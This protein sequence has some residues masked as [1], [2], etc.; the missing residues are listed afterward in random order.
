MKVTRRNALKSAAILGTASLAGCPT[1]NLPPGSD[2][3]PD[4]GPS[5]S[6]VPPTD[7][8][9]VDAWAYDGGPPPTGTFQHGVASGD[10]MPDAVIL[11]TRVSEQT[12]AVDVDWEIATDTAFAAVVTSGTFNTDAARDFTVKV[13]ATGL[14]P[15][16][17]YYYR[18]TLGGITSPI[19]RTKTAPTGA[20]SRLRFAFCSCSNYQFGF[21]H[22]YRRI[23][24]RADLDAVIHLGDYIYEF[25][26][27]YYGSARASDPPTEILSL[28][29]YRRRYAHYREDHDLQEAHRQHP[30]ITTWDDHEFANDA[31]E[32]G[33]QNHMP[34]T[35]G[36]WNTRKE[37]AKQ[38]YREWMPYREQPSG[39]IRRTL[40]YGDLV[41]LII[42][43][44]R[45]E[46]RQEQNSGDDATRELLGSAQETFLFDRLMNSPAQ[47]KLVCQQVMFALSPSGSN[48]DQWEGYPG[49]RTRVIEF[50][51]DN[52]IDNAVILTGDIHCSWANDIPEDPATYDAATGAG[53]VAVEM[54][55]PAI[56]SPG[57]GPIPAAGT[58]TAIEEHAHYV[59]FF[60]PTERGYVVLDV[61]TAR[62][63]GAWY[64]VQNIADPEAP[65]GVERF[66]A[67]LSIADGTT[68]L[69]TDAAAAP[70][71]ADPPTLAP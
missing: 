13:D 7:A 15:A 24:E 43:D 21:F 69:V 2:G 31:Y 35:E 42:L 38:V 23:S 10:P 25:Q 17:T 32:D 53:S 27:G 59:R 34:A 41:E 46:A 12:A 39:G 18:F 8:G 52:A 65:G 62:T 48:P 71:V 70:P 50:L 47:W 64:F 14:S 5:D 54:V 16:T 28:D 9:P 66:A 58:R 19:G 63:Q 20:T 40:T 44:T 51:R 67:A 36:D 33:A 26:N 56:T 68:N 4:G 37:A 61:D 6:G 45:V 1:T 3:G 22:S 30:F 57:M 29:D 11:W 55:C 60:D 49:A